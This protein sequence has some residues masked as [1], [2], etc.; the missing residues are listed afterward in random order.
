MKLCNL[1]SDREIKITGNTLTTSMLIPGELVNY[2]EIDRKRVASSSNV[3]A[4]AKLQHSPHQLY[5]QH[6]QNTIQWVT[7]TFDLAFR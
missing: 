3:A 2:D 7:S 5:T 6:R 4:A 1:N